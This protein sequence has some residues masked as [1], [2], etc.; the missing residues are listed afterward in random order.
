MNWANETRLLIWV[1]YNV[2]HKGYETEEIVR[3]VGVNDDGSNPA[4]MFGNRGASL[5]YIHN[6][7]AVI[8]PLPDD[9]DH[10]IMAAGEPTRG[11]LALYKV[12]VNNGEAVVLEYGVPRTATWLTQKGVPMIRLDN[13][14]SYGTRIMARAPGESEYKFVHFYRND[15]DP[16]FSIFGPT[17]KPGVFVGAARKAGEDKVTVR[18]INLASLDMGPPLSTS[19]KVDARGPWL[20]RRG[21]LLGVSSVDDRR[22]Y[23][24]M[25]K[26]FAPHYRAIEKYFGPELSVRMTEA[27]DA[28][29]HYLGIAS[30]PREPGIYFIYDR[31]TH[32]VTEL[33]VAHAHLTQA[34]LGP[35]HSLTVK[36]RDG[37]EIRAYLTA[38]ASGTPGPLVVMPHGG[39]EV[40]DEWGYDGWAQALAAQGWWV[41]QPNFRGSGGYGLAF[42]QSGWRHWGDRMQEDIEDAAA[43][44]IAEFKLD[45]SKVAIMGGSYGGY[46]ALMGAV[47]K[48][49]FYKAVVSIAGVSDVVD[50][51]KW[52]RSHDDTSVKYYY[53]FWRKRI[54]DPE[55]DET[56]L[57]QASPRRR[58]A[59]IKAP[60]FLVHG[61]LDETVPVEQS[62]IMAKAL[63]AAGK[64]VEYWE[65]PKEGHS[66]STRKAERDRMERVIAFLKPHLA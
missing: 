35:M 62:K 10:V 27:D 58:A 44:A 13:D 24:F 12:D 25:E 57:I 43:Q 53:D 4:V 45:A 11:L 23:D 65:I 32:A 55:T 8:D 17:E 34:R 26:D 7:G 6:L 18:E 36:T 60:V 19:D 51:L 46:A 59:E 14:R 1:V 47:R 29:T 48:A 61:F 5:E 3:V 22:G 9:S 41:L 63:T 15:Q 49:D 33:G 40:R 39:P 42:A 37:A 38:P 56:M 30:G 21:R 52:E 16:E 31:S 28:R 20:D 66:A 50:I 64:K 54:G 2:T